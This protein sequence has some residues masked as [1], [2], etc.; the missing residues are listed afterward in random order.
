LLRKP[1]ALRPGDRVAIVAP[2]SAFARP[3]FDAG[4]TELRALGFEPVHTDAVFA[5]DE[6]LAGDAS[7]RARDLMLAW[8]DP[9]IKGIIA[10]R[11]GYGS[12]HL[13]PLLDSDVVRQQPK[14]FV[15]YSDNTSLLVWLQQ[16][17][18]LVSFHGP[19]VE[20][21]FARGAAGYDRD[22]FLRCVSMTTPIGEILDPSL[23]TVQRGEARGI[24]VGG[25]LTQLVASM[26]TPYAFDPPNGCVLFLDDVAERPYRLDRMLTQ[27]RLGG[28][29]SRPSAIVFN[30]LPRCDEPGGSLTARRTVQ[31]VLADFPGPILFG[32]QSGHTDGPTLTLPFGVMASVR[33]DDRPSVV[34]EEA[35]V[36]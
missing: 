17:C 21:R 1:P 6:Y 35:A 8:S 20:G 31:R 30:S 2:A 36:E 4:V 13:L 15:G 24:L 25:T 19:M 22:S 12:V 7:V 28:L 11:G 32:L 27:L 29:L 16:T 5:R 10:A 14:V 26:G 23:E 9:S 18:G 34:I 3:E 33:A